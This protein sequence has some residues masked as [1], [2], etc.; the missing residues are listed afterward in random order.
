MIN[1]VIVAIG[2]IGERFEC[3]KK[4]LSSKTFLKIKNKTLL[5]YILDNVMDIVD[6]RCVDLI[7]LLTNERQREDL[8]SVMK[9]Y[10]C[11]YNTVIINLEDNI[12]SYLIKN[13]N[14]LL[15]CGDT[16]FNVNI[17][18]DIKRKFINSG[19]SQLVLLPTDCGIDNVDFVFND[20]LVKVKEGIQKYE[21]SQVF[22]FNKEV[23][24]SI[25]QLSCSYNRFEILYRYI[26]PQ[27][28]VMAIKCNNE[29]ININTEEDLL[30]IEIKY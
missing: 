29:V 16:F 9:K 19:L 22:L 18:H 5:E 2:G 30:K 20:G 15:L 14:N 27:N 26:I 24:N 3:S 28:A 7:F 10:K 25:L 4:K 21:I 11:S 17:L 12:F 23:S 1:N 13:E 6:F 8:N